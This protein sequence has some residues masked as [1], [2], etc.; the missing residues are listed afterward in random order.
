MKKKIN[1]GEITSLIHCSKCC[2]P[3]EIYPSQ[4]EVVCKN[5]NN[6]INLECILGVDLAQNCDS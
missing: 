5:C 3:I 6:K 2:I 4:K 1:L